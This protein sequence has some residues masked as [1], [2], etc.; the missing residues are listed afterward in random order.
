MLGRTP[1]TGRWKLINQTVNDAAGGAHALSEL[2]F[3]AL[4][5]SAGFPEPRLQAMRRDADGR[6][7]YIDALFEEYGVQVEIDGGHH[8]DIRQAWADMRRQNAL[9]VSGTRLLRFPGWLVRERPD[10]VIG[11]LRAALIAGG[12]RPPE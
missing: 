4:C 9:W 1:R 12:W 5:R 10:E 3:L 7:R 2:D 11:Q 6:R 8:A